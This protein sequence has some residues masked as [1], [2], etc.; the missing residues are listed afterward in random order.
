MSR[1]DPSLGQ[2]YSVAADNGDHGVR[3]PVLPNE[4]DDETDASIS[5]EEPD[6]GYSEYGCNGPLLD[7]SEDVQ[8]LCL[9]GA[10]IMVGVRCA[11]SRYNWLLAMLLSTRVPAP[12]LQS[13]ALVKKLR[14]QSA[15]DLIR[16]LGGS[17]LLVARRYGR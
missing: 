12:S 2:L 4:T 1:Y 6:S 7:D 3:K 5:D 16:K 14:V 10:D 13:H 8:Y 17:L 9:N 11:C 15:M